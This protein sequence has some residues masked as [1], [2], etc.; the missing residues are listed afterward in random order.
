[1]RFVCTAPPPSLTALSCLETLHERQDV[2]NDQVVVQSSR[3]LHRC[4]LNS[5]PLTC[6]TQ[7]PVHCSGKV[8]FLSA[9]HPRRT[10]LSCRPTR[11]RYLPMNPSTVCVSHTFLLI[12]HVCCTLCA[13]S[14]SPDSRR[15]AAVEP[16]D[17]SSRP[18]WETRQSDWCVQ[19]SV[20]AHCNH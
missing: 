7:L 6:C 1:M 3:R 10:L 11:L 13:T 14:V 20:T 5:P 9:G 17:S 18:S 4:V 15:N 19:Q 2:E 8:G 16:R 12:P